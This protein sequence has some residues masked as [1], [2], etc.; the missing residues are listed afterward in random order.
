MGLELGTYMAFLARDAVGKARH[1]MD[2]AFRV[3]RDSGKCIGLGRQE[4]AVPH[5]VGIVNSRRT[6]VTRRGDSLQ[7]SHSTYSPRS[8]PGAAVRPNFGDSEGGPR[9]AAHVRFPSSISVSA[10]TPASAAAASIPCNA[11]VDPADP[12]VL[13]VRVTT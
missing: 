3:V 2:G 5:H 9:A 1:C 7:R 8:S 12:F 6:V 11:M 10:S 13:T 4:Q